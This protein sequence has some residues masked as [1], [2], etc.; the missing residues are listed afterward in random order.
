MVIW[1][2]FLCVLM[3][4]ASFASPL[5]LADESEELIVAE[6]AVLILGADDVKVQT[7]SAEN[8]TPVLFSNP[9]QWTCTTR[10]FSPK[11]DSYS[12]CII[13]CL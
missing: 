7:V 4:A 2:N 1:K 9:M 10:F 6:P 12:S 5:A 13:S 11:Y 8:C 3:L